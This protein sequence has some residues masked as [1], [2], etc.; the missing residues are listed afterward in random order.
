MTGKI[1]LT[2]ALLFTSLFADVNFNDKNTIDKLGLA[3]LKDS[4]K[5]VNKQNAGEWY[6]YRARKSIY[7]KT[8]NDE[9]EYDDAWNQSY[10][11]L[12]NKITEYQSLIGQTSTVNLGASFKK[13]DF[14]N[15]RFPLDAMTVRSYLSFTGTEKII[16]SGRSNGL[17]LSFDNINLD[18][19]FVPMEKSSAKLFIKKRKNKYGDV[20]RG[21]TAK[22]T[23]IIKSIETPTK[24][25]NQ[26]VKDSNCY[27]I[28]KP[29]LIGHITKMDII[30]N[31]GDILK[32]YDYK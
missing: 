29:K 3:G 10:T 7:D 9:F 12:T 5:T 18:Y 14:K 27:S 30:D 13:Y 16:D 22:Y 15:K 6:L 11:M 2:S 19:N 23:F 25:L 17:R 31:N 21:L 32:S 4:I 24:D 20:D 26:C 1:L 8:V 28:N